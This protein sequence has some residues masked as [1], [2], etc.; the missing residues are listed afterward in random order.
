MELLHCCMETGKKEEEDSLAGTWEDGVL[1]EEE[2]G[3]GELLRRTGPRW[4]Y[5]FFCISCC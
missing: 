5:L 2:E 1:E 4:E 3:A